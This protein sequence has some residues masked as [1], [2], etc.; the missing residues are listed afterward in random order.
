[1]QD[2]RR[3]CLS[4][5]WTRRPAVKP[6]HRLVRQRAQVFRGSPRECLQ[7]GRPCVKAKVTQYY[8]S[9]SEE[10]TVATFLDP[11]FNLAYYGNEQQSGH[12]NL[13]DVK[14]R[15][16]AAFA[17][18]AGNDDPA[19]IPERVASTSASPP[20]VISHSIFRH[21]PTTTSGRD[22]QAE[23]LKFLAEEAVVIQP[24][25]PNTLPDWQAWW[26]VNRARYPHVAR[27]AC[28]Y[29]AIPGSSAASE[30]TFSRAPHFLT[31]FRHSLSDASVR[32]SVCLKSWL[33]EL[34]DPSAKKQRVR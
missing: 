30:R 28:D 14:T 4:H 29:L 7:A 24:R 21:R 17:P 27:M 1:M 22:P 15:A 5:Q 16:M 18:Y 34:P 32:A 33:P 3:G 6:R 31:E 12:M 26:T 13:Q 19:P 11:R 23:M 25:N 2:G 9:S 10:C 8:N 20:P